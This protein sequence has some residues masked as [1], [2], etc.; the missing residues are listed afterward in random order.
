MCDKKIQ[1]MIVVPAFLKLLKAGIEKQ[2]STA[3]KLTSVLFNIMYKI[4]KF[5]PSYKIKRMMFKKIHD[6]MGGQFFGCI[7]GG[8]PLDVE[9]GEFFERIGIEVHQ[10]YGLSEACPVV[11]VNRGKY[12]DMKS[13]GPVLNSFDAKI[14]EA[15]G[16][17]MLKG[18]SVMKGYYKREDLTAE[19]ITSEGW[20]HTGDIASI[21]PKTKLVYITGRIKNMIVLSGGKKVFPEEIEIIPNAI[22]LDV[23][24]LKAKPEAAE[25]ETYTVLVNG[26]IGILKDKP[27]Q[28]VIKAD[29]EWFQPE[30]EVVE[31]DVLH[32]TFD[33][34]ML[35]KMV[36]AK[37]ISM[38]IL[39][40]PTE[41]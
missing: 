11:A 2:I 8:A 25:Y 39:M 20:L 4:A 35:R 14:D 33:Q 13:I 29:D 31:D 30:T 36:D 7:S 23:I 28:T 15:T 27:A 38:I 19:T 22:I 10:G 21:D 5:I 3:P 37:N 26:V 12:Q 1:F 24:S 41:E 32:V 9:V 40:D 18:P 17:L 34:T 6:S 16:E